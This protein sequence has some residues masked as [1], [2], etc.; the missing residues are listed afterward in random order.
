MRFQ[1]SYI[2]YGAYWSTPFCKWQGSFAALHPITFAAE[3]TRRALA[4]R[5]LPLDSFDAL[6][7]GQTVPATSSF[8]GAPWLAGLIGVDAIT[9]PTI[10]QACATSA[11]L[12]ATAAGEV[13]GGD[14]HMPAV[15]CIATDRTSNGPHLVYPDPGG[16]G[17]RPATEDWVW[18]NFNRDPYAR[19]SM[20][21][22]AENAAREGG[23]TT[24]AQHEVVLMRH[25][26]YE[27]ALEDGA[28]FQRRYMVSPI[29]VNPTGKKVSATVATDEGV[30]PT[31][32]EGL[33]KLRPVM[34]DGT[35]TFGAQTYPADG[36]AGLVLTGKAKAGQ[37]ARDPGIEVRL[38]SFAQGRAKKGFMPQANLPAAR[39]ALADA[40]LA[41]KDLAAIKT[42]NPFAVNDLCLSTGLGISLDRMNNFG[43]SLI[44]GHPQGPTGMRLVIELIEELAQRG[45][46]YGLFTGCAAGDTAAALVVQVSGAG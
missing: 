19:N 14:G 46:G 35:V 33:R 20:I 32:A 41:L 2:P 44:W 9:G 13:E 15:L 5:N 34:P 43:S 12:I 1:R 7:L 28:A 29:E 21:E 11:R 26:Q 31:T 6:F 27:Q 25:A 39:Q 10:S 37:L 24:E 42:H 17:G 8:Y 4:E 30:F 3:V 38:L 18:D 22:T 40:D 16:A 45:G 36:N 23:F